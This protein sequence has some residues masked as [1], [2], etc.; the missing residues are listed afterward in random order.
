M[1]DKDQRRAQ[2]ALLKSGRSDSSMDD[3]DYFITTPLAVATSVQIPL[4]TIRTLKPGAEKILMLSSDSSMD[5]KDPELLD[6]WKEISQV[7]IP[8][9]TIRTANMDKLNHV[10]K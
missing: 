3:K 9:W 2:E 6:F 5:D 8:L 7:Q 10:N 1:D 4:W